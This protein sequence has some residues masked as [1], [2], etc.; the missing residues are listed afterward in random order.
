MLQELLDKFLYRYTFDEDFLHMNLDDFE[1]HMKISRKKHTTW[2]NAL[3]FYPVML[4][5][6]YGASRD[7]LFLII[8]SAFFIIGGAQGI[9]R[10]ML[11]TAATYI[12]NLALGAI[13]ILYTLYC[14]I[15]RPLIELP[16]IAAVF[17]RHV[18]VAIPFGIIT[19]ILGIAAAAAV[20][21]SVYALEHIDRYD[22]MVIELKKERERSKNRLYAKKTIYRAEPEPIYYEQIIE[23]FGESA[24]RS[25]DNSP[26]RFHGGYMEEI[27][28]LSDPAATRQGKTGKK[29]KGKPSKQSRDGKSAM[30]SDDKR[31]DEIVK[32]ATTLKSQKSKGDR[33][34]SGE[35]KSGKAE[36]YSKA[37]VKQ[38]NE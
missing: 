29:S 4:G 32:E 9:V 8:L 37:E 3:L 33:K 22:I 10:T 23:K 35:Q 21:I 30:T 11:P 24:L 13:Y 18:N 36:K 6:F 12:T 1:Y 5:I 38:S 7:S 26:G 34:P 31:V 15:F 20:I 19:G 2:L 17:K 16:F 25:L 14:V 27:V 28:C